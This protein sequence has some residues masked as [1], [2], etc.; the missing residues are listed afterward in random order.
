M[1]ND[2]KI[3]NPK[4]KKLT[5]RTQILIFIPTSGNSFYRMIRYQKIRPDSFILSTDI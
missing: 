4:E 3:K 5:F 2:S 1:I